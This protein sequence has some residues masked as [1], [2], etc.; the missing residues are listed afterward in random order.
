MDEIERLLA[1]QD[2]VIAR[3]QALERGMT[4]AE[5]ARA[6][7]RRD[8]VSVHPGV[9]VHHTGP[10]TW[11]QRAWAAVLRCWP[12]ALAGRS[13]LGP[14]EG[15]IQ[16]VV[17][18]HRR[19]EPPAGVRLHRSSGFADRVQWNLGPP[20]LRIEEAVIDLA[21]A[22]R[23]DVDAV[24]VL[25]DA[26][27]GRRTTAARLLEHLAAR[28]RVSRRQFLGG[29]LRDVAAGACSVLEHG[30]LDLVERPHGLPVGQ[31]QV[32]RSATVIS[33]V[34][35][36]DLEMLVELD[37]RLFHTSAGQRDRDLD[38]DLDHA[39]ERDGTTLRL[40]YGQIFRDGCRTAA[41]VATVMQRRGW[42]GEPIG[43]EKCG[44]PD[45][46]G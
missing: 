3:R 9:Y 14:H 5:I 40:G 28:P 41:K 1:G 32:V 30:Y 33:D 8:W 21:V 19:L 36:A 7:R 24:A 10:L 20:R 34:E 37:G 13:A 15:A 6:L 22:A 46:P 12:A 45:Q 42:T 29:V 27:G 25:A 2:G 26:C 4:R 35:Y 23:D 31:R 44:G 18:R 39:T 11:Q 17:D 16:V 38:R 43:C